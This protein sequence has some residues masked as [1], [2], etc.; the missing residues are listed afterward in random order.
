MGDVT[1][2][3]K[4]RTI[5]GT[6]YT[7][8]LGARR[9]RGAAALMEMLEQIGAHNATD[10]DVARVLCDNELELREMLAYVMTELSK[11]NVE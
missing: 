11:P 5:D 7:R 2:L 3:K 4:P 10:S 9:L 1:E 8:S 6:R